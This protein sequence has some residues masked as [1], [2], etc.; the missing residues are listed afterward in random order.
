M[1]L[2][3]LQMDVRDVVNAEGNWRFN[4]ITAP[5]IYMSKQGDIF[6]TD[7]PLVDTLYI[8]VAQLYKHTKSHLL[9]ECEI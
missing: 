2:K 5:Q 8:Y 6:T 1:C 3:Y 9:I 7:W 4:A